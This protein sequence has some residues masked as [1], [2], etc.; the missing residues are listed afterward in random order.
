[1]KVTS[2]V[3]IAL[4]ACFGFTAH[5]GMQEITKFGSN[6]GNLK[7]Y[8]Y[9]PKTLKG[10]KALVLVLHG[11]LQDV[12]DFD[13]ESG[14]TTMA[15]RGGFIAVF[16]AQQRSNNN[17]NCFNWFQKSD[18]SRGQG[19]LESI[20]QMWKQTI[21]DDGIDASRM[22][23]SGFSSGGAVAAALLANYPEVFKGAAIVAGV[24]YGCASGMSDAFMCMNG[25]YK[26]DA[27]QWGDAVRT[28]TDYKGPRA[29]VSIWHGTSDQIIK[30]MIGGELVKQWTDVA[31]VTQTPTTQKKTNEVTYSA[32][33]NA[34]G[35]VVVEYYQ[36]NGM[37]HGQPIKQG[38]GKDSCGKAGSYVLE[39][40]VCASYVMSRTWGLLGEND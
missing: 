22:Y 31:G 16:P 40:G 23:L 4:L 32:F 17:A 24:P 7:M 25:M 35:E 12:S 8:K 27:K 10:P 39:A 33:A 20:A 38:N 29:R 21:A 1:M 9:T 15:E 5:A 18:A 3:Q 36:V 6:P 11:C 13:D 30:P 14:W 34:A 2:F 19:E 28:A 37:R 26:K